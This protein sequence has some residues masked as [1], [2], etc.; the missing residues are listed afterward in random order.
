MV[1]QRQLGSRPRVRKKP[2]EFL[3]GVSRQVEPRVTRRL[4]QKRILGEHHVQRGMRLPRQAGGKDERRAGRVG[5]IDGR[6]DHS[7]RHHGGPMLTECG[8]KVALSRENPVM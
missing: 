2:A 3:L 6:E 5:E 8:A 1:L 7:R 4:R